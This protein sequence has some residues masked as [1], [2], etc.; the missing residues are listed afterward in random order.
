MGRFNRVICPFFLQRLEVIN[1]QLELLHL[2]LQLGVHFRSLARSILINCDSLHESLVCVA[3]IVF[4]VLIFA[5]EVASHLSQHFVLSHA[6][7]R[8]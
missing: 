2:A 8:L 1:L 7:V 6:L 3:V 4:S 5:D